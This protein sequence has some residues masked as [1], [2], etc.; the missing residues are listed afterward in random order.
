M[1]PRE[2]SNRC[3]TEA[4]LQLGQWGRA[5]LLSEILMHASFHLFTRYEGEPAST[6]DEIQAANKLLNLSRIQF[7]LVNRR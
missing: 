4:L 7:D 6:V 3:I 5:S 1:M 2:P